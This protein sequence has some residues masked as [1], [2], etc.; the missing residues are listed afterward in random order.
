MKEV[1]LTTLRGNLEITQ[2][3]KLIFSRIGDTGIQIAKDGRIWLCFNGE[4]I[5]RF[6]PLTKEQEALIGKYK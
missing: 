6:R 1:A 5:I 2:N 4:S 3:G